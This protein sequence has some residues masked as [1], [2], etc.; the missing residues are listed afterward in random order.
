[1]SKDK[2]QPY[3]ILAIKDRERYHR[4]I[5][6]LNIRFNIPIEAVEEAPDAV[7]ALAT[8]VQELQ[9][10]KKKSKDAHKGDDS[11]KRETICISSDSSE[12]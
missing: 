1:L 10:G 5:K 2:R 9:K 4:E 8:E 12:K 3:K 7:E 6:D 11:N